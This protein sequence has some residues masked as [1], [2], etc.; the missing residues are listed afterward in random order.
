MD[1]QVST[2]IWTYSVC[3]HDVCPFVLT[4]EEHHTS[5]L[6]GIVISTCRLRVLGSVT[7]TA[8][9][10]SWRYSFTCNIK[11]CCGIKKLWQRQSPYLHYLL[12]IHYMLQL[13]QFNELLHVNRFILPVMRLCMNHCIITFLI[14]P[15]FAAEITVIIWRAFKLCGSVSRTLYDLSKHC[16]SIKKII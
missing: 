14:L 8:L 4:D 12:Q 2:N 3:W 10:R 6:M 5:L 13:L 7:S 16:G 1:V 9:R 11:W 15:S